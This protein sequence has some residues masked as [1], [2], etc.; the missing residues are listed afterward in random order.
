MFNWPDGD[1]IL[2]ATH[3]TDTRDFRVHKMFLSFAS[4]VFKDM[5][6]LPQPISTTSTVDIVDMNDPPR[7]LDAI[8]R[9]I[10]PAAD[11]PTIN[12]I[13]F[14]SEVLILADKYE[15]GFA[16]CRLR[17]LLMEFAKTDPLR[18]YAIACRLGFETETKV[19]SWNTRSINLLGL[20][21]LP[22]EFKHLSCME[23]HRLV[24]LH[25]RYRKE[26][27]AIATS[28]PP[29]R[30]PQFPQREGFSVFLPLVNLIGFEA[31][32]QMV[33]DA[34]REGGPL[35]YES[36]LLAIRRSPRAIEGSEAWAGDFLRV[37]LDKAN[38]LN[39]TV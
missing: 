13:T 1:I 22:N 32:R 24:L 38:A 17:P 35:D 12:D 11:P 18:T 5:F 16:R 9:F 7:A 31:A 2:R 33:V 15:I 27:E 25:V 39:L 26:V 34:I 8:L 14:L 29:L 20:T 3:D 37:V 10:Y 21:E 19:A 4:P 36:L 30:I 28:N 23:Y 6:K